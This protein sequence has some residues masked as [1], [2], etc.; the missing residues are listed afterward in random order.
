[1]FLILY[2]NF[3]L[4]VILLPLNIVLLETISY[5]VEEDDTS[6]IGLLFGLNIMRLKTVLKL[7]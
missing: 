7:V 6:Q 5:S 2:F 1:M 3:I 4:I